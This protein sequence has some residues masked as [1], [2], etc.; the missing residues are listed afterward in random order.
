M[1]Q[2]AVEIL[3]HRLIKDHQPK[4]MEKHHQELANKLYSREH[5]INF[6]NFLK[7]NKNK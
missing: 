7:Q 5:L 6:Y 1:K 4:E 2:T 3:K